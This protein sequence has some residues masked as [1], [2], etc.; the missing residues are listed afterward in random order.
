MWWKDSISQSLIKNPLFLVYHNQITKNPQKVKIIQI[1]HHFM[2]NKAFCKVSLS[3]SGSP[4]IWNFMKKI[5]LPK[6]DEKPLISE[7]QNQITKTIVDYFIYNVVWCK[8]SP[9]RSGSQWFWNFIPSQ[10]LIKPL[11]F[12]KVL[13]KFLNFSKK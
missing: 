9:S 2:L 5:Y 4:W 3:K 13:I 12:L 10:N 1:L 6:F 8:I 11:Y 7:Y